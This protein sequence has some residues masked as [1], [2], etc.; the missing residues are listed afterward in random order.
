MSTRTWQF[1][2]LMRG[3]GVGEYIY[4]YIVGARTRHRADI[5]VQASIGIQFK[6]NE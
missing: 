4:I 2:E 1:V 5:C 6:R 3:D